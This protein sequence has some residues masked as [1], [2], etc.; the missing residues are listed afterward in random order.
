MDLVF[1]EAAANKVIALTTTD[2]VAASVAINYVVTT[3]PRYYVMKYRAMEHVIAACAH[4]RGTHTQ[5]GD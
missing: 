5:T 3:H 4:N 1:T 2:N